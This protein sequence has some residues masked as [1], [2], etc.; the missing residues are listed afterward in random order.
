MCRHS[1]RSF[2][3]VNTTKLLRACVCLC[4]PLLGRV[5]VQM[6]CGFRK[7]SEL[8]RCPTI[9]PFNK[10]YVW[11]GSV[12]NWKFHNKCLNRISHVRTIVTWSQ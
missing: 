11:D 10:Y 3:L 2:T 1:T 6:T 5:H 4:Y 12:Q 8:S 9:L 7:S